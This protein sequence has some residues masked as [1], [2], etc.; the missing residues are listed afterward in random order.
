MGAPAWGVAMKEWRVW[1]ALFWLACVLASAER[2]S[3]ENALPSDADVNGILKLC[4]LGRIQGFEGDVK[5]QV[6]VWRR[7]AEA[8]GK[9]SISDLGAL[10]QSIKPESPSAAKIYEQ[11]TACVKDSLSQFLGTHSSLVTPSQILEIVDIN[12]SRPFLESKLGP[13]VYA[14]TI[15]N[16]VLETG[17]RWPKM[18]LQIYY[19]G[20]KAIQY[21]V[22]A[23]DNK[24]KPEIIP[25]I[26]ENKHS[27]S[28]LKGPTCLGCAV[29][30]NYD[31]T[32]FVI[33]GRRPGDEVY[34]NMSA[35]FQSFA[36]KCREGSIAT[37]SRQL[38][39]G[40]SSY[41]AEYAEA[42]IAWLDLVNALVDLQKRHGVMSA[43]HIF[44][45]NRARQTLY[46]NTYTVRHSLGNRELYRDLD[47]VQE[48]ESH[49]LMPQTN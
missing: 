20:E 48:F 45:V 34:A 27:A 13:P 1:V 25:L 31:C 5:G 8:T 18:D 7:Q 40:Y 35:K 2:A 38:F 3:A 32:D 29:I 37:G 49:N 43:Q 39:I 17:F 22:T 16:G 41:G 14:D 19:D 11:Y 12:K 33:A 42:D 46:P 26:N 21:I 44:M 4:A 36:V 28:G 10:L 24:Y 6:N 47:L 9:A 23:T 15:P 30:A